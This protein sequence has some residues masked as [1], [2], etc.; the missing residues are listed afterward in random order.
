MIALAVILA[1]HPSCR[2]LAIVGKTRRMSA[3]IV[4]NVRRPVRQQHDISSHQLHGRLG[5]RI[6][7]NRPAL[8][9]DVV[10]NLVRCGLGPGHTPWLAVD[11]TDLQPASDGDHLQE[12]AQPVDLGHRTSRI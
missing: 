11:A 10:G 7:D 8:E 3:A 9:H 2:T 12:L 1:E 6:L 4:Q 5:L